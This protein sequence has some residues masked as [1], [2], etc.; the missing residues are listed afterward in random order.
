MLKKNIIIV[1]L[2]GLL[3]ILTACTQVQNKSFLKE[4]ESIDV[5]SENILNSFPHHGDDNFIEA[6]YECICNAIDEV[7]KDQDMYTVIPYFLEVEDYYAFLESLLYFDV[8]LEPF[9]E[10]LFAQV[11]LIAYAFSRTVDDKNVEY[12]INHLSQTII[13]TEGNIPD[14]DAI[15][16]L[17]NEIVRFFHGFDGNPPADIIYS[18][19]NNFLNFQMSFFGAH[20][21]NAPNWANGAINTILFDNDMIQT[22]LNFFGIDFSRFPSIVLL[23]NSQILFNPRFEYTRHITYEVHLH[24]ENM[25]YK[26][27]HI[28]IF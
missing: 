21:I 19:I 22:P 5:N 26:L 23:Y 3:I 17:L 12:L 4:Y 7:I 8:R 9:V 13:L 24:L 1:M 15:I 28:E 6:C 20:I 2:I 16:L 10:E 11:D 14:S 18:N 27:I 25:E